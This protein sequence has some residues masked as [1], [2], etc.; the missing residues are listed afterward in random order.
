MTMSDR[1]RHGKVLI[2]DES[3]ARLFADSQDDLDALSKIFKKAERA[4]LHIVQPAADDVAA[5]AKLATQINAEHQAVIGA[6]KRGIE[7]AFAAGELLLEAK[8]KVGHGGWL[9]WLAEN[10]PDVSERSAQRYMKLAEG[11][12]VLEAKSATVAD[13]TLREAERIL[14]PDLAPPDPE[15]I[16][17]VLKFAKHIRAEEGEKRR[18]KIERIILE[19]SKHNTPLP[20]DCRY[21]VV[22]ADPAW[23]FDFVSTTKSPSL[24]YPVM[25]F[26]DIL[27][28]PV[29][30]I[31]TPDAILFIWCPNSHLEKCFEVI[32]AW[33]FTYKNNMVWVKNRQGLGYWVRNRHELLLIAT[34]GNMLTPKSSA[35]PPS[36]L[37]APAGRHSE[38][39]VEVY[40]I[41]ER[42]YPDF[43]KIELFARERRPGWDAWGNE[44]GIVEPHD[45]EPMSEAAE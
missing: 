40:E 33:G 12:V 7:H 10:C 44:A 11:R 8:A 27:A 1:Q 17:Q 45:K 32:A 4:H 13:L 3:A 34:R 25:A 28:L 19:A 23:H 38:K 6:V 26:E 21:P 42:M 29:S 14:S 2:W 30:E 15:E 43:P 24:H 20:M 22:Y 35:R 9:S 18:A 39:P 5:L 36:V 16:A 37:V 31:A 41:I